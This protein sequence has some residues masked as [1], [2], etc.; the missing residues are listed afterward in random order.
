MKTINLVEET[1]NLTSNVLSSG[2][3]VVHDTSG[4]GKDDVTEL[5]RRQKVG[6]PL[7]NVTNLDVE[8]GRNNTS[9]VKTTVKLNNDLTRTVIIDVL[10]LINVSVLLHDSQELDDDLGRRSNDNL[11]LTSLFSVGNGL[12][13]VSENR[14]A[15][16]F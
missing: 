2:F 7:L 5:S 15:S 16:H 9:L 1:K 14:S 6:N 11:S 12:K 3:F 4:G 8:S 10:E 13:S